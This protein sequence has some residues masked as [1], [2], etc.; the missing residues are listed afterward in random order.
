[1]ITNRIAIPDLHDLLRFFFNKRNAR[2][3]E[4]TGQMYA[5]E[6]KTTKRNVFSHT[7]AVKNS[8]EETT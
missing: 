2:T 8:V 1:M 4:Q 6:K 3:K 7:C 5:R